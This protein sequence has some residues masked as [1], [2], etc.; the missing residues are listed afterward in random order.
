MWPVSSLDGS[1]TTEQMRVG[2]PVALG[3]PQE[4]LVPSGQTVV[5]PRGHPGVVRDCSMDE[6]VVVEWEGYEGSDL[7]LATGFSHTSGGIY[8]GLRHRP[9]GPPS[10][11]VATGEG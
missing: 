4:V 10:A 6:H 11:R 3:A 7:S 9:T 1:V 8:P 5:V 2:L